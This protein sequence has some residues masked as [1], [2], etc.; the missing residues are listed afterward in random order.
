MRVGTGPTN[1]FLPYSQISPAYKN[2]LSTSPQDD[3]PLGYLLEVYVDDFMGLAVP[4]SQ[5]IL[6]HV[7]NGVMYGIHD[8]FPKNSSKRRVHGTP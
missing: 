8:V 2:L 6:D 1:K 3:G 5:R 4:T 7:S